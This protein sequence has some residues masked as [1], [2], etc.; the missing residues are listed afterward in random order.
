MSDVNKTKQKKE[1]PKKPP[2]IEVGSEQEKEYLDKLTEDVHRVDDDFVQ[3]VKDSIALDDINDTQIDSMN[4]YYNRIL[5]MQCVSPLTKGVNA[6]SVIQSIGMYAGMCLVSPTF[7]KQCHKSVQT[8][9]YPTVAQKAEKA[10]PE[11]KWAKRRDAMIKDMNGG[12]MPL[13][14]K[15]AALQQIAFTK[16]FYEECRKPDADIEGLVK[17]Y[18]NACMTLENHMQQDGLDYKEVVQNQHMIIGRMVEADP[19]VAQM[20]DEL[21]WGDVKRSDY[22]LETVEEEGP[23]GKL[24]E[25]EKLVWTGEFES[26]DGKSYDEMLRPRMPLSADAY[27]ERFG[28]FLRDALD[29]CETCDDIRKVC[30]SKEHKL[31]RDNYINLMSADGFDVNEIDDVCGGI[32]DAYKRD[33]SD[34]H[35]DA[36]RD[37]VNKQRA[38]Q[39][40]QEHYKKAE[41]GWQSSGDDYSTDYEYQQ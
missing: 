41:S 37:E 34:R 16:R 6:S 8:I 2:T 4:S 35:P 36:V 5:M 1:L 28:E 39:K 22:R 33:W 17:Q 31:E 40:A 26:K 7:R 29:D 15:S 11:S 9:L 32:L 30:D 13:T 3:Y 18:D 19:L 38:R 23:D 12:R 10:G 25:K 21:A 27:A 20:F 14:P 24:I